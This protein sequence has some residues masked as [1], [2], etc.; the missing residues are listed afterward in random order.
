MRVYT[1]IIIDMASGAVLEAEGFDYDGPVA[2]CKGGGGGSQTTNTQDTEYNARMATIA[3]S[4]QGMAQ[5]YF[6]FWKS[7]YKPLEQEQIAANREMVAAAKPVRDKFIEE[8]LSG[9]NAEAIAGTARA[10]AEQAMT[11]VDQGVTRN[12]SRLGLNPDSEAFADTLGRSQALTRARTVT[13]SAN[14]A[15]AL[16]R[17][18][19]YDRLLKASNLGMG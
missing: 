12:L 18:E 13:Q 1:R 14:T 6:N 4:Q 15:R 5:E 9:V 19:N 17:S 10:D 7:D 11:T 8:S 16:A 2:L 3:E